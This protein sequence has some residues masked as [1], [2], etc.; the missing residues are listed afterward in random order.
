[1]RKACGVLDPSGSFNPSVPSSTGFLKLHLRIV[2]G[3]CIHFY[4]LLGEAALM[5]VTQE[6]PQNQ[7]TWAHSGSQR[8][9]SQPENRHG[10][11]LGLLRVYTSC[12]A[13]SSCGTH[14]A[15]VAPDYIA[16]FGFPSP[17]WAAF[18]S[19]DRCV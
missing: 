7:L 9:S 19:F 2:V 10:M 13:G 16:S 3:L 8:L 17:H 4:Q 12:A 14:K 18:F 6:N 5:T 11:E 1:M 15:R